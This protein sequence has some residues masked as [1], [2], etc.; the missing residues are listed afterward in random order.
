MSVEFLVTSFIII[1]SPGVGDG[2][3][4]M[5][6]GF[7]FSHGEKV[8]PLGSGLW[9]GQGQA[10]ATGEG[11]GPFI[12]AG[13]PHPAAPRGHLLPWERGAQESG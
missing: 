12:D 7:P 2:R 10:A 6:P 4:Q 8:S 11:I 13:T 9:P 3:S 1:V 5:T